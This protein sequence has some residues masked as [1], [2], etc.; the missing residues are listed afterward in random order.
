MFVH[1]AFSVVEENKWAEKRFV[2]M[3]VYNNKKCVCVCVFL[4]QCFLTHPLAGPGR[5]QDL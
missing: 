4:L 2:S 5:L 3:S 1:G